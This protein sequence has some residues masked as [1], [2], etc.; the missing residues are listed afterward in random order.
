LKI[1]WKN[2][3]SDKDKRSMHRILSGV[4]TGLAMERLAYKE[5]IVFTD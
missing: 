5:Q 2:D 1:G 4:R 3:L